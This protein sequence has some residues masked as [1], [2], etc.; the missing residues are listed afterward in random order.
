M[1]SKEVM[2]SVPLIAVLYDRTFIADSFKD[3][4]RRRWRLW[5]LLAAT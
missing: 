2:V 3:S 1:A 4:L 5:L